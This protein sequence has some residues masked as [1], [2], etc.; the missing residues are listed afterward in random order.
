MKFYCVCGL[1]FRREYYY[2]AHLERYKCNKNNNN[3]NN[4]NE[5]KIDLYVINLKHR[6]DRWQHINNLF[7][8][9][10]N[11]IRVDAV[12]HKNGAVG[13]FMSHQKC[14]KMAKDKNM[15][16]IIVLEDDCTIAKS[17]KNNLAQKLREVKNYLEKRN[18]WDI[19]LG[20]CNRTQTRNINGKLDCKN[21]NLLKINKGKCTHFMMYNKSSYD[22]FLSQDPTTNVIDL[23]WHC[24]LRA[25]VVV[26]FFAYQLPG[27]S[28]I[29]KQTLDYYRF[30]NNTETRLREYIE[31][32]K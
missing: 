11:L 22:F 29:E 7:G 30:L 20:G 2:N 16:N 15:D 27:K 26:P 25:V 5:P 4:N 24:K 18:D 28:D 13:C 23:V 10:F 14:I 9:S 31:N 8:K 6:T 1:H 21:N 3:N 19:F 12:K 32:N 17:Y